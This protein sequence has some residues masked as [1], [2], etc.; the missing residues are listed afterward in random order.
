MR[1]GHPLSPGWVG[2]PDPGHKRWGLGDELDASSGFLL[3]WEVQR[4]GGI[5]PLSPA[6]ASKPGSLTCPMW[7]VGPGQAMPH[8]GTLH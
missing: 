4:V 7:G 6:A 8:T 1:L 3:G 2:Q 5:C